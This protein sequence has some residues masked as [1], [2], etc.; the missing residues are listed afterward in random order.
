MYI[1][2]TSLNSSALKGLYNKIRCTE[3]QCIVIICSCPIAEH[4]ITLAAGSFF[5]ISSSTSSPDIPGMVISRSTR[6]GFSR[7]N[8][9][10]L[11]HRC[12]LLQY[13]FFQSAF[14]PETEKQARLPDMPALLL[15]HRM[16]SDMRLLHCSDRSNLSL[17]P[18]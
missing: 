5:R 6:S 13:P 11:P 1:P 17:L 4:I 9:S 10:R 8:S 2:T 7:L 12:R 18:G 15:L 16:V 3:H 14:L